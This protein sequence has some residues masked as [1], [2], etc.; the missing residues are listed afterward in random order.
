MLLITCPWCGPR[1][2][3]EFRCGGEAHVVRPEPPQDATDAVWTGYLYIRNNVK[4]VHHERW[5]HRYG[6]GG[7][8]HVV[9]DTVSH[10]VLAAYEMKESP[11]PLE[12]RA[13]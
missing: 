11:P 6:C 8:F 1:S 9:R 2:E 13:R 12:G 10:R 4:G 3:S 7:W 5:L